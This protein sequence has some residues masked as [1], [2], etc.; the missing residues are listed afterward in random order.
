MIESLPGLQKRFSRSRCAVGLKRRT[1]WRNIAISLIDTPKFHGTIQLS[2]MTIVQ[3]VESSTL[4]QRL[5]EAKHRQLRERPI[6]VP[7]ICRDLRHNRL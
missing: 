3:A 7:I 6:Y 1:E 4:G 2:E 5:G